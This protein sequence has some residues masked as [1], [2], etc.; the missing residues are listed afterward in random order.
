VED[1]K[2]TCEETEELLPEY[3]LGVLSA[4]YAASVAQHLANCL[5]HQAS[6]DSYRAVCDSLY[7]D[8]PLVDP[9]AHLKSRLMARVAKP[10][11]STRRRRSW[12]WAIAAAAA[13]LALVFGLWGLSLQGA[14]H[15]LESEYESFQNFA[16][17]ETTRMIPLATTPE[18]E[19]AKGVLFVS[20]SQAAIWTIGLPRSTGDQIFE[21]WWID[22]GGQYVSA[23]KFK[24][25]RGWGSWMMSVPANFQNFHSFGVTLEPDEQNPEPQG[26]AVLIGEF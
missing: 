17:G 16:A 13:A 22:A 10:A 23:G 7:A 18:G 26:P 19:T 1:R 4:E 12:G 11:P 24:A 8:V 5:A 2:L 14:L 21:C 3:V 6:L 9:P 20:D 15:G 25:R